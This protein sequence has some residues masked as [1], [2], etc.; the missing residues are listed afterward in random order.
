MNFVFFVVVFLLFKFSWLYFIRQGRSL[1]EKPEKTLNLS[2]NI[3]YLIFHRILSHD[4]PNSR[5]I[6]LLNILY[7]LIHLRCPDTS[8]LLLHSTSLEEFGACQQVQGESMLFNESFL[9]I[10]IKCIDWHK[11]KMW[12]SRVHSKNFIKILNL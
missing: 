2:K 8:P 12:Q 9:S 7:H 1:E 5:E 4:K 3:F 6:N 10:Y 11:F